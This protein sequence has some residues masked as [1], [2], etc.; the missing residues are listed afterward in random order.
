MG[1]M[2][3]AVRMDERKNEG[4]RIKGDV[5]RLVGERQSEREADR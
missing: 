3:L 1:S 5:L 4:Q 2:K